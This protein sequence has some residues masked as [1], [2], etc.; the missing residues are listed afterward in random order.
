MTYFTGQNRPPKKV[1]VIGILQPAE[2]HSSCAAHS[3][4]QTHIDIRHTDTAMLCC[5]AGPRGN[6]EYVYSS[7]ELQ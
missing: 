6:N 5:F 7:S 4:L 1:G 3:V 2:R